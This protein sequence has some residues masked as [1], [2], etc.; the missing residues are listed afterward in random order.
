MEAKEDKIEE[1]KIK[2]SDDKW[3]YADWRPSSWL[4]Q[5]PVTWTSSSSSGNSGARTKRVSVLDGDHRVPGSRR[6]HGSARPHLR[7]HLEGQS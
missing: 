6:S 3:N 4:W 5:Q 7:G 1:Q 2:R